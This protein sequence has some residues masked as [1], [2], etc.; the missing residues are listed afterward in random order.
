M[1]RLVFYAA[2]LGIL[3]AY[4]FFGRSAQRRAE[5]AKPEPCAA[6]L[7]RPLKVM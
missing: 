7:F 1:Y 6:D 4:L 3:C 5:D 2:L